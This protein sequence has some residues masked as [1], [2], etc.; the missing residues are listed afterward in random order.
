MRH[1]FVLQVSGVTDEQVETLCND[2]QVVGWRSVIEKQAGENDKEM[3][4]ILIALEHDQK[5]IAEA[6][7]QKTSRIIRTPKDLE[8]VEKYVKRQ[9][10]EKG[11]SEKVS[12]AECFEPIT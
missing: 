6:E 2:L 5:I 7:R 3:F 9:L 8:G 12:R 1:D 10:E 4:A 11:I